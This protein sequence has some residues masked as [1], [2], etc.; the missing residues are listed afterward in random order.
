MMC[1]TVSQGAAV[2]CVVSRF[3]SWTLGGRV[4]VDLRRGELL[5]SVFQN[6]GENGVIQ[7]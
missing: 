2:R 7:R 5:A 6:T 4:L 3:Q 1:C